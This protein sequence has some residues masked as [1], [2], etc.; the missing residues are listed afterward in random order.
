MSRFKSAYELLLEN[1]VNFNTKTYEMKTLS[2]TLKGV[3]NVLAR[4]PTP[5][6]FFS[7]TFILSFPP[8][9][10]SSPSP[11]VVLPGVDKIIRKLLHHRLGDW[12]ERAA[13]LSPTAVAWVRL[14]DLMG[15]FFWLLFVLASVFLPL[16]KS[17]FKIPIRP[18]NSGQDEPFLLLLFYHY[19]PEMAH[20]WT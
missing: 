3:A 10:P 16:Q 9:A 14:P 11:P 15:W 13:I 5:S 8:P 2:L 20:K 18:G 6:I 1:K 4:S 12:G 19:S 7:L 17:T